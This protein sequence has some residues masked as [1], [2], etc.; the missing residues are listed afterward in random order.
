MK[1]TKKK[2]EEPKKE[3]EVEPVMEAA[4]KDAPKS[5]SDLWKVLVVILLLVVAAYFL[6]RFVFE[7]SMFVPGS[8]VDVGTFKDIFSS[9]EKVYIF[10]DVR[11]VDNPSISTNI[12]QCGVD[13]AASSGMAGKDVTYFSLA[14]DGCI[15]PDGPHPDSYCFEQIKD[16]VTIYVKEGPG[17]ANYYTNGMVV[18]VGSQ[19]AIGTC[20]IHRV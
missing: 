18:T 7:G 2:V 8:E 5:K 13:F 9:A 12:L 19:Y 3:P 14:D 1:K 10:M 6:Y 4:P 15:A 17:G 11:G 16:G 20:G